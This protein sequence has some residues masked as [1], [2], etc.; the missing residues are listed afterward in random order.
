MCKLEFTPLSLHK[1]GGDFC[2]EL[3]MLF[4]CE[5]V[6]KNQSLV[7][8]PVLTDECHRLELPSMLIAG[9]SRYWSLRWALWG[10]V[11]SILLHYRIKKILKA[12]A[13]RP[14]SYPYRVSIDYEP[15]MEGAQV[16]LY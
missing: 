15:W 13:R 2:I 5:Q 9:Q 10:S 3:D 6:G 8:T 1:Q 12:S 14:V 16:S 4:T 7:F 11:R